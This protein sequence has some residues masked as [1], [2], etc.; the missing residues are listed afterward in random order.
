[1]AKT[2]TEK[3]STSSVDKKAVAAKATE[4]RKAAAAAKKAADEARAKSKK[5]AKEAKAAEADLDKKE[6]ERVAAEKLAKK[7]EEDAEKLNGALSNE[8]SFRKRALG[9]RWTIHALEQ[10]AN[11]IFG[12]E[13][14]KMEKANSYQVAFEINKKRIPEDGYFTVN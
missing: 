6:K 7:S 1:M 5:E 2:K 4:D 14:V 9:Q 11:S 8:E 12:K 10:E 3:K 13:N